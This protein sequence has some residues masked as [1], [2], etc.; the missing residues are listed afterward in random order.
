MPDLV[1]CGCGCGCR[2]R[3]MY[4]ICMSCEWMVCGPPK[5]TEEPT[6]FVVRFG[7]NGPEVDMPLTE[8][9]MVKTVR[10]LGNSEYRL[11]RVKDLPD[12]R[13]MACF[14]ATGG[15]TPI[16]GGPVQFDKD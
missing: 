12:G 3:V 8:K 13:V 1:E 7:D 14:T 16:G 10:F 5:K 15:W 11:E 4:G 2:A 9:E 6:T